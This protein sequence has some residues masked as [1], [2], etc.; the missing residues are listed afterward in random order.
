MI[1][2]IALAAFAL[3]SL[4]L[5]K[6]ARGDQSLKP[7]CLSVS[8]GFLL[9]VL[10]KV[11]QEVVLVPAREAG[12]VP[13]EGSTRAWFHADQFMFLGWR[14]V[15][16]GLVAWTFVRVPAWIPAST[17]A[18]VS[19]AFAGSYP[20]LRQ[21][22]LLQ[23]YGWVTV[24]CILLSLA[25]VAAGTYAR[26]SEKVGRPH[27]VALLLTAGETCSLFGPWLGRPYENWP[28]AQISWTF[29]FLLV[30]IAASVRVRREWWI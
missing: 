15:M 25:C 1:H 6:A 23:A 3:A 11:I 30:V 28:L 4:A 5:V 29:F 19:F 8:L 16:L 9:D 22:P 21:D 10:R 18:I 20:A 27:L 2:L 13:F 26:P 7:A 17:W 12:K 14:A 24:S